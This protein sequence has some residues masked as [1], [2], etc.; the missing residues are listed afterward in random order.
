LF[1]P[2]F[3][4][5]FRPAITSELLNCGFVATGLDGTSAAASF[6]TSQEKV[7]ETIAP[8]STGNK[9]FF[10]RTDLVKLTTFFETSQGSRLKDIK[11]GRIN[12]PFQK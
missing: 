2:T 8:I 10:I 6:R 7:A 5:S 1:I 12:P 4:A 11:K 9:I 3:N